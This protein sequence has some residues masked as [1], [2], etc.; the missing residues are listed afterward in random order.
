MTLRPPEPEAP[1]VLRVP[2][3][4]SLQF[5]R[6]W[7]FLWVRLTSRCSGFAR[8]HGVSAHFRMP[9]AGEVSTV[10][11]CQ[12]VTRCAKVS[13]TD[14]WGLWPRTGSRAVAWVESTCGCPDTSNTHVDTDKQPD[15][16]LEGLATAVV[17]GVAYQTRA[18]STRRVWPT[19]TWG[20]P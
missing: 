5:R 1:R 7:L 10:K 19:A 16:G 17:R 3:A 2:R 4:F 6:V 9:L 11:L 14:V 13:V 8:S 12:H 15:D 20:T 18:W